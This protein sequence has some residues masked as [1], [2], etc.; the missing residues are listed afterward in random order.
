MA[1]RNTPSATWFTQ[2]GPRFLHYPALQNKRCPR[3][4]PACDFCLAFASAVA[5][6]NTHPVVVQKPESTGVKLG[7][8]V[9]GDLAAFSPI[10]GGF[11]LQRHA[12]NAV[13]QLF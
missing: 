8:G 7:G 12:G 2:V 10:G 13:G 3:A 4:I 9:E 6:L 11:Q 1:A 5:G